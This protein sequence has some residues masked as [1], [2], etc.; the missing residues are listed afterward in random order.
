M[1]GIA[2]CL[3]LFS[4]RGEIDGLT[5][6]IAALADTGIAHASVF[7]RQRWTSMIPLVLPSAVFALINRF[8]SGWLVATGA[9]R[10]EREALEAFGA[11]QRSGRREDLKSAPWALP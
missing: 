2:S 8:V 1:P 3:A 4:S 6:G 11:D 7:Q 5:S 9:M 10:A